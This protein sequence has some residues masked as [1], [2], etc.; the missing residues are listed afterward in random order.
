LTLPWPT[1]SHPEQ[2]VDGSYLLGATNEFI[3]IILAI[4]YSFITRGK[5]P[6]PHLAWRSIIFTDQARYFIWTSS[7]LT[8]ASFIWLWMNKSNLAFI[9]QKSILFLF[10][11]ALLFIILP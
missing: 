9:Y 2:K 6:I 5:I 3:K 8:G 11:A 10:T 7:A 1:L 4:D